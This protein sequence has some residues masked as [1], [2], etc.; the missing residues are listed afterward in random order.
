MM[1]KIHLKQNSPPFFFQDSSLPFQGKIIHSTDILLHDYS[2]KNIAIIG[3]DQFTVTHLSSICHTAHSVVVFQTKPEFILPKTKKILQQ[4]LHPLLIKNRH[5]LNHRIQSL[6]SL[7]FLDVKVLNH[8]LKR[9]L[10]PNIA[11][12]PSDFLKS[13][14]YYT[15]LQENNCELVTWPIKE[16]TVNTII[17]IDGTI[18]PIDIIILAN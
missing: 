17:S 8:W 10:S 9:Q 6:I 7:R 15:A 12:L 3:T 11:S 5:Q 2:Y 1:K 14:D 18:F 13:D 16:I 4:L